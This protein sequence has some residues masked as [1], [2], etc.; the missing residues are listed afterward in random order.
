MNCLIQLNYNE[1]IRLAHPDKVDFASSTWY[2]IF[3]KQENTDNLLNSN[4]ILI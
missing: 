1:E 3:R 2:R 4:S